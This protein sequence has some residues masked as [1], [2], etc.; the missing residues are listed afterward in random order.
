MD[1]TIT[2]T[3]VLGH[4]LPRVGLD[5]SHA[6]ITRLFSHI[7]ANG[8]DV[9]FLSSRAIA[10]VRAVCLHWQAPCT[11]DSAPSMHMAQDWSCHLDVASLHPN[12][13]P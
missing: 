5:W 12:L 1:G 2:R 13:Q 10:Q 7:R 8:Y 6:G 3:D 9:L 11:Y 4:I